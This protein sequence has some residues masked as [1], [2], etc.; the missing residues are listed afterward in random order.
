[1]RLVRCLALFGSLLSLGCSSDPHSSETSPAP[2]PAAL[3]E[4]STAADP[5]PELE[6][7]HVR[8]LFYYERSNPEGV[9]PHPAGGTEHTPRSEGERAWLEVHTSGASYAYAVAIFPDGTMDTLW[10]ETIGKKKHTPP[11]NAFGNGLPLTEQFAEG[12]E[13][14][15]VA[16]HSPIEGIEQL[17]QCSESAASACDRVVEL[18]EQ[19]TP[20]SSPTSALRMRH[21]E[22]ET[23]AYGSM[24][25]GRGV[26][27]VSFSVKGR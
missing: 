7:L 19:H 22:V 24:N 16:S 25:S 23:P 6:E 20:E 14:L 26:A 5:N 3:P 21:M 13:V 11:M 2:P 15:V 10:V 8:A 17:A 4:T 1:M 12:T 9:A 27:A 18:L